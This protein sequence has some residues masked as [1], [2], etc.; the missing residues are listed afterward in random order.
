[1]K[2][3]LFAIIFYI[4]IIIVIILLSICNALCTQCGTMYLHTLIIRK[5]HIKFLNF[6]SHHSIVTYY[7]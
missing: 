7:V 4:F 3:S 5:V 6:R 1:M 2:G